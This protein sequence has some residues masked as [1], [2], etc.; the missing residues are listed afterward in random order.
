MC[1][2]RVSTDILNNKLG[3]SRYREVLA[4]NGRLRGV[5]S[6]LLSV[7]SNRINSPKKLTPIERLR[8]YIEF[9]YGKIDA[10][11]KKEKRKKG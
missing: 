4:V 11:K 8:K 9:K 1:L 5:Q 3:E 7:L 2:W 10:E 6:P